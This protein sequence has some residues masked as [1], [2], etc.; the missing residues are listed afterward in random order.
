MLDENLIIDWESDHKV[1]QVLFFDCIISA[2]I[3][4][5]TLVTPVANPFGKKT[6][7]KQEQNITQF[8]MIK[9]QL[10]VYQNE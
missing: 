7:K 6:T 9:S 2:P 10:M 3:T 1:K 5:L 4:S 8:S